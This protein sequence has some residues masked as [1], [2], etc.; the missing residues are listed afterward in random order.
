[1]GTVQYHGD[2]CYSAD[3]TEYH[4]YAKIA[5]SGERLNNERRPKRVTVKSNRSA[6]KDDTQVPNRR[7]RQCCK[8]ADRKCSVARGPLGRKSAHQPIFFRRTEPVR[9]LRSVGQINEHDNA[10]Q[11]RGKSF[12]Q[13]QPLP[14]SKPE[15]SIQG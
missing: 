10:Q 13:K 14:S 12:H 7:V 5:V 3:C 15:Q 9:C 2:D 11:N 4:T 1:M 8:D 6:E